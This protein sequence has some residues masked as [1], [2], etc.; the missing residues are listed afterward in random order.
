[1]MIVVHDMLAS[2]MNARTHVRPQGHVII[3]RSVELRTVL[4]SELSSAHV[5]TTL[6]LDQMA[7]ANKK[8][9]HKHV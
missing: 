5:Q 6:S 7:N 8:V 1:M 9:Y 4:Q 2:I 3:L